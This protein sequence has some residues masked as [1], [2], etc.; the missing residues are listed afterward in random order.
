MQNDP[1]DTP[2]P[3][4]R[5][6]SFFALT[7]FIGLAAAFFFVGFPVLDFAVSDLFFEPPDGPFILNEPGLGPTLRVAF[8]WLFWGAVLFALAG[9]VLAIARRRTLLGFGFPHYL[10]VLVCVIVG[11]GLVANSLLKDNW[12]RARPLHIER[13]DGDQTYTPVLV[14]SDQC[15]RNCSFV[16]GEA[17]A[18]FGVGFAYALLARRR[19]REMILAACI[20]GGAAGLIRIG[21]GGHFISDVVFAGVFMALVARG[22]YWLMLEAGASLLADQGPVHERLAAASSATGAATRRTAAAARERAGPAL[23]HAAAAAQAQAGVAVD[24]AAARLKRTKPT[25]A[26]SAPDPDQSD[27]SPKA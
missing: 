5:S 3:I 6:P 4:W 13:Y 16:A 24:R 11:P 1:T 9:L 7:S 21:Q 20:A 26:S 14:R 12:G 17:A 27:G 22:L 15:A 2:A 25:A 19:R 18:L 23:R 8:R 10:F